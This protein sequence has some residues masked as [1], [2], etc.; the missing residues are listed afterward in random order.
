[1]KSKLIKVIT[2]SRLTYPKNPFDDTKYIRTP[3]IQIEG[4]WLE[5]LGFHIGDRCRWT[6]KKAPYTPTPHRRN[7]KGPPNPHEKIPR[8]SP[9]SSQGFSAVSTCIPDTCPRSWSCCHGSSYRAPASCPH[10][11]T[12]SHPL[13]AARYGQPLPLSR[14]V[15]APCTSHTADAVS[16][17]VSLPSATCCHIHARKRPHGPLCAV[18]HVPHRNHR[19]SAPGI[20]DAYTA[21]SAFSA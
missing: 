5:S 9:G 14:T 8:K 13:Y 6:M 18:W 4:N 1:M 12:A 11:R 2:S 3:K 10:P 15:P 7:Q 21:S 20:P 19:P 17:K 16:E